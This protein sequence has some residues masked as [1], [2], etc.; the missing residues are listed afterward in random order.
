MKDQM[1]ILTEMEFPIKMIPTHWVRNEIF[2]GLKSYKLNELSCL[3]GASVQRLESCYFYP[4]ELSSRG[5]SPWRSTV[6]REVNR[7]VRIHR[8][9]AVDCRDVRSRYLLAMTR[10]CCH[11][12][13]RKP[14]AI[15]CVSESEP[16][17]LRIPPSKER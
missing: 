7:L 17:L 9:H 10:V 1:E 3:N 15:H 8:L 14:V 6:I 11:R 16:H 4:R 13:G 5:R 12:E 2:T